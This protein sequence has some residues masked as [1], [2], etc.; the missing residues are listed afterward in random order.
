MRI[1]QKKR[2]N[3]TELLLVM[4]LASLILATQIATCL[5]DEV[6]YGET[7]SGQSKG[8]GRLG[9][10]I[11][12]ASHLLQQSWLPESRTKDPSDERFP[13]DVLRAK[14]RQ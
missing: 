2:E 4:E 9:E 10:I 11:C 6:S 3:L 5:P 8:K 14:C 12:F 1:L 7:S 13:N